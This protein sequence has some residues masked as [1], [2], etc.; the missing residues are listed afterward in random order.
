LAGHVALGSRQREV[1]TAV[2]AAAVSTVSGGASDGRK[3]LATPVKV[4]AAAA[5]VSTAS[6]GASDGR[7]ALATPVKVAA[8]AAAVSTASVVMSYSAARA[9]PLI[10][11]RS[12][13]RKRRSGCRGDVVL[14]APC[15]TAD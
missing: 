7:K 12:G 11:E 8:A 4:A 2:A 3:A 5:A 13:A 14:G 15:S 6:G 1:V 9:A 10:E